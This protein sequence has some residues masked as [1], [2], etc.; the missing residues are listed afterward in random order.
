MTLLSRAR[1]PPVHLGTILVTGGRGPTGKEQGGRSM[2]SGQTRL[3]C[4]Q[5]PIRGTVN[6]KS[7]E[8]TLRVSIP[9]PQNWKNLPEK[10]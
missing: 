2:M 7:S 10:P 4:P 6:D 8:Q 3:R 1:Q 5:Y 9:H